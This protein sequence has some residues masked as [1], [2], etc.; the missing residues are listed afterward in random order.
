MKTCFI[1]NAYFAIGKCKEEKKILGTNL[2]KKPSS[3]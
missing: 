2:I 1:R 3:E